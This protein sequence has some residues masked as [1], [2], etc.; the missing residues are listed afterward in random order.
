MVLLFYHFKGNKSSTAKKTGA[1]KESNEHVDS[2]GVNNMTVLLPYRESTVFR[3][4]TLN[5]EEASLSL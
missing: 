5:S 3:S 4:S 1:A 2:D